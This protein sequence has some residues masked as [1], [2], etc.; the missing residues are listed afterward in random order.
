MDEKLKIIIDQFKDS[1]Y[2]IK[3]VH[4]WTEIGIVDSC[5]FNSYSDATRDQYDYVKVLPVIVERN[6]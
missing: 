4:F 3:F 1:D 6:R 2:E 5:L